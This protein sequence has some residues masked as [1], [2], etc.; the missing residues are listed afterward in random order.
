MKA[1]NSAWV[2][3]AVVGFGLGILSGCGVRSFSV[4]ADK[5]AGGA[6][7]L[8]TPVAASLA[9]QKMC[10]EQAGKKFRE[11]ESVDNIPKNSANT[12]SYTSHYDPTVNV[13]YVRVNST[14]VGKIPVTVAVVYDAFGG[15]VFAN[16]IWINSHNKQYSDVSPSTC[17]VHI[18]G[19]PD[20]TCKT[21]AE[22]DEMTE[23][24]FGVAQ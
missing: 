19:R 24:Y 4:N 8:F 2:L 12:G 22:F 20:E 1:T 5:P 17:E 21:E 16:Y 10:D 3:F 9:Q 13:C 23:K 11:N 14:S 7:P 15:R 18:P 6:Q